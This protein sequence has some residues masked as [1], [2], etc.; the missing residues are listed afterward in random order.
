VFSFHRPDEYCGLGVVIV[1]DPLKVRIPLLVVP[2]SEGF[3]SLNLM[4]QFFSQALCE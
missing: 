3:D 1:L 2:F 4:R